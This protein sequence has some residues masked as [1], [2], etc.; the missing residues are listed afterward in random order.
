MQQKTLHIRRIVCEYFGNEVLGKDGMA[1]IKRLER[2]VSQGLI[3]EQ[4]SREME[5]GQP[6]IDSCDEGRQNIRIQCLDIGQQGRS[7]CRCTAQILPMKFGKMP[8]C[9]QT[10]KWQVGYCTTSED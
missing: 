9:A 4:Q 2:L 8:T 7:L 3:V 10:S 5:S 6:A 1:S